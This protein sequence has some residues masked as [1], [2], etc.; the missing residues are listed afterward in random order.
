MTS[1]PSTPQSNEPAI[2]V[3]EPTSPFAPTGDRGDGS[4][5]AYG[6]P[7]DGL[8]RAAVADRPLD[9]VAQLITLLEQSPLYARATADALRAV[10]VNRSVDDVTRLVVLLTRPPR[11]ASGA[12]EAIRAA[13]ES[14]PV[15]EVTRLMALLQ[16]AP[17]EPHCGQEAVRAAATGRPV[18][19]LVELIGRLADERGGTHPPQQPQETAATPPVAPPERTPVPPTARVRFRSA[20]PPAWPGRLA[21]LALFVCAAAY[22]PVHQDGVSLRRYGFVLGLAALCLLLG[23]LL[24]LRPT[25]PLLTLA[26]LVPAGLA[27]TQLYAARFDA[28][29]LSHALDLTLAPAWA[30]GL[31]AVC[32]A[33]AA[34]T[35]L[36][37]RLASPT[38]RPNPTERLLAE[39][40]R[41]AD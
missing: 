11:D 28:G 35:A 4:V 7:V 17:L 3:T 22:F 38:P 33:L 5:P 10:G 23:L 36:V 14:R 29:R 25:V 21:A 27:A 1:R 32:A 26:V 6:D 19:D 13:A 30:A 18:E 9:E 15:E 31:A 40:Q 16:Q 34:L 8:V 20:T 12:D 24:T 41:T 37:V 2:S 39:A